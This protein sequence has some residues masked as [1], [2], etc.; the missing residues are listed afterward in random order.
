MTSDQQRPIMV[1]GLGRSGTTWM[2][3]YLSQHPRIHIHGQTPNIQWDTLWNWYETLDNQGQWSQRA[4][5]QLGLDIPHYAGSPAD[6]TREVFKRM[7]FEYFTGNGP[8][9]ERWGLK[10][11]DLTI[12][13]GAARQFEQLWP[14]AFWVVCI[15]DPF[16]MI[17]SAKNTFVPDLN[18]R[19]RAEAWV[20]VCR[21]AERQ[22]PARL[23]IIQL[24][25]LAQQTT[26]QRTGTLRQVL[27]SL[28]ESPT[29]ETDSFIRQWPVV[30][31]VVPE[32]RRTFRMSNEARQ[33]LLSS[34]P[35][36]NYYV[37]K[38]GYDDCRQDD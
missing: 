29:V 5:R 14:Q 31:K 23:A 1:T 38:L 26:E 8:S 27:D 4:N 10:W 16:L 15:R 37:N 21:F 12:A 2:Q 9:R 18:I 30:H 25:R 22:D 32:D 36:L 19:G 28:G 24:D 33:A 13:P 3:S 6:R 34:V 7:L 17:E 11:I 35:L 20:R